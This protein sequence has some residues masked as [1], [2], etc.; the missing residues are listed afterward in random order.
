MS[1]GPSPTPCWRSDGRLLT[2]K[3]PSTPRDQSEGVIAAVTAVLERAGAD[4]GEITRFSHGMTVATNALLEG[5]GA[6]TAFVATEG[7]ADIVALGRQNRP[8]LYRLCAAPPAPLT[9]PERRFGAPER[10]TPDGPLRDLTREAAEGLAEEIAAGRARGGGDHA[11]ALLPPPR[12]RAA[13]GHRNPLGDP[14][15]PRLAVARGCRHV[16]RVRAREHHRGRRRPLPLLAGYLGGLAKRC[17]ETRAPRAGDHAVK[18]R[19]DRPRRCRGTR[20]VDGAL[21]SG[22]GSGGGSVRGPSCRGARALCFDMGGTSCDVC[23]VDGGVV[24]EQSSATIAGR[25][26]ALPWSRCTR[27]APA[28]ARS[29]G[30]TR[31]VPFASV[32]ARRGPTPARRVTGEAGPSPP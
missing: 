8:E 5:N 17:R 28:E 4:P 14:R 30:A 15:G 25:P 31:G 29:P 18:R 1:A 23:V 9:P 3:A 11:P 12:A 19:P 6:R 20:R 13:V 32:R 10:M 16:P 27:S 7:F 2:A 26:L 24:Q 21:G 22:R